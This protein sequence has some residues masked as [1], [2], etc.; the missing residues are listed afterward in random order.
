MLRLAF[1]IEARLLGLGIVRTQ[2][3]PPKACGEMQ[4][5]GP[6]A[7]TSARRGGEGGAANCSGALSSLWECRAPC[8]AR[9]SNAAYGFVAMLVPLVI[10]QVVIGGEP[11]FRFTKVFR[12]LKV[13]I[14][15]KWGLQKGLKS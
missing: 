11:R 4:N 14:G 13:Q 10:L 2:R 3:H 15:S 6:P 8:N 1:S 7:S 9:A 12:C 5:K